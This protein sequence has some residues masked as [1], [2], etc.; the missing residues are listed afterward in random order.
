[1]NEI[2]GRYRKVSKK[3]AHIL[4]S[5]SNIARMKKWNLKQNLNIKR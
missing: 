4:H 1:M 2:K 5:S 3:A